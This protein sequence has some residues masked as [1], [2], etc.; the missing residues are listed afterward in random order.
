MSETNKKESYQ[1][2]L[3][4]IHSEKLIEFLYASF[5]DRSKKS[6]KSLLEHRQIQVGNQIITRFDY[7]VEPG[8]E[9][10]VLK[11]SASQNM[12]LQ[13]M[14]LLYEDDHLMIIDKSSGLLSV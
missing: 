6:V 9:V 1:T 12:T 4:A 5:P 13:M 8:Q 10:I 14:N 3:H 2:I 7:A 11:K